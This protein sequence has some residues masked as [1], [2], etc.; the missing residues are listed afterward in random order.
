MNIKKF[1][2][3]P[4]I[5][6]ALVLSVGC[7]IK[8]ANQ[9]ITENS[10]V[11]VSSVTEEIVISEESTN[12]IQIKTLEEYTKLV[13]LSK[14]EIID[15]IGEEPVSLDGNELIFA[16]SGIEVTLSDIGVASSV[17]TKVTF[18]NSDIDFNGVKLGSNI[19]E[20]ISAFGEELRGYEG[21]IDFKYKENLILS[22]EYIAD[23]DD[24]GKTVKAYLFNPME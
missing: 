3:P 17:V 7:D 8:E 5:L 13:D 12:S 21:I 23:G 2:I 24:S 15:F 1:I 18:T 6:L 20:F 16:N 10:N 9:P 14:E 22:I 11:S 4:M 19:S